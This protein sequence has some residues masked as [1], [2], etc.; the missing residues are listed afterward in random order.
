M[1]A[2]YLSATIKRKRT[3]LIIL[4]DYQNGA[5][6]KC[7]YCKVTFNKKIPKRRKNW[8]H[9]DDNKHNQKLWNLAWSCFECNQRKKIE[10]DLKIIGMDLTY[11]NK[12]WEESQESESTPV[13]EKSELRKQ[14][15]NSE[16]DL[17]PLFF[18]I[19]HQF[20]REKLST[21]NKRFTMKLAADTIAARCI[22]QQ[23]QGSSVTARRN[24]DILCTEE[25]IY[26][27]D[28]I[29]GQ[30]YIMIDIEKKKTADIIN[31][32]QKITENL[33]K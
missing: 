28:K 2:K 29:E 32:Q 23:G 10:Y 13:C 21:V 26:K 7:C 27:S 14:P 19:A 11:K 31:I 15:K 22:K 16:F 17:S 18:E 20:L 24:L 25:F 30:F 3:P 33:K 6:H 12:Q 1:R 5:Q 8:E 4:R 9:L